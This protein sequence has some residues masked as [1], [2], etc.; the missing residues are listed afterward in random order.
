LL[1]AVGLLFTGRTAGDE[2]LTRLGSKAGSRRAWNGLLLELARELDYKAADSP[3]CGLRE[4]QKP[5]DKLLHNSQ[6]K[7]A[8]PLTSRGHS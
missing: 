6:P 3:G 5:Q 8:I 4:I 2:F 7:P 1:P